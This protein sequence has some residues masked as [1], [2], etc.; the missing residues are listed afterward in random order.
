EKAKS[1]SVFVGTEGFFGSLPDGLQIYLE[2]I[3]NIRVIGVGWPVVE[4]SQSLINSLVDNDVYLLVNQSRLK[5]NPKEKGL[6][7]VEEYPKAIWPDGFQDK[8]LLFSLDKDY[9]QQ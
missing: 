4:V 2:G 5:L 9:F 6:I 7:L 8:L 1:G 3:P